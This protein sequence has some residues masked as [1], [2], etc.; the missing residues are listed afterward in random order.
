MKRVKDRIF[1]AKVLIAFSLALAVLLTFQA[2]A[3]DPE[4][5]DGNV[6]EI[7]EI[8]EDVSAFDGEMVLIEGKIER[9]CPAGCW[10]IIDDGTANI[11]VDLFPNDFVIPQNKRGSQAL[12]YGKVSIRDGEAY[13]I[14]EIVKIGK[15][16]YR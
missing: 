11:F 2:A 8:I 7:Q 15:E 10:F 14:G 6:T 3:S 12:V 5:L 1:A 16:I 4:E 9:V 13:I